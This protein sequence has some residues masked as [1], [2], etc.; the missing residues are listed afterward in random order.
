MSEVG[1][2]KMEL[3]GEGDVLYKTALICSY[4]A[5]EQGRPQL[6]S[7]MEHH[8]DIGRFASQRLVSLKH[9]ASGASTYANVHRH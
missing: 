9:D 8:K 3:K 4:Q 7:V 2:P 1:G 6:S 5:K